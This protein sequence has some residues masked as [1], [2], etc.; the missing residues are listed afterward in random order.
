ME[1][2]IVL[3]IFGVIS[4][5]GHLAS[6]AK[7]D[8]EKKR[9]EQEGPSLRRDQIPPE[10]RRQL[11]G[12]LDDVPM[13]RPRESTPPRR[14]P[15][16]IAPQS[17]EAMPSLEESTPPRRAQAPQRQAPQRQMPQRQ[18]PDRQAPQ[19]QAPQVQA[20][21]RRAPQQQASAP[22]QQRRPQ[23]APQRASREA[24]PAYAV[25]VAPIDQNTQRAPAQVA[26]RT[27][28]KPVRSASEL[29]ATRDDLRRGI[30]ASEVLG[31]P[32]ALR[33]YEPLA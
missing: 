10:I 9:R 30:L 12:D 25:P 13:A 18:I 6:K 14:M 24:R 28:G 4:L 21:Q 23:P 26:A 5:V 16:S 8:A 2:I 27:P 1:Q 31:P 29:F 32:R 17:R 33:P 11:Y 3:I 15:P 7:E 20:P 19:R 22:P